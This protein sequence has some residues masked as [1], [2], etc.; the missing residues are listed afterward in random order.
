VLEELR[1]VNEIAT[2]ERRRA[3]ML[4][5]VRAAVEIA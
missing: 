5:Q 4:E 3:A 1:E 2:G